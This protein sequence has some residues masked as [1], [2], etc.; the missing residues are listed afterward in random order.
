M[1]LLFTTCSLL[2]A[3]FWSSTRSQLT[4]AP[5][6]IKA[7]D[8]AAVS[9]LKHST[10][11]SLLPALYYRLTKAPAE[12]KAGDIAAASGLKHSRT[13]DTLVLSADKPRCT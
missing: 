10:T 11:C 7:G 12:I 2:P 5:A 8:I 3:I 1:Y 13:G 6:E 4:K 9:G